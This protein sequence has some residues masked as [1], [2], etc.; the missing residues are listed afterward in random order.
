VGSWQTV[1][2]AGLDFPPLWVLFQAEQ[3]FRAV[4]AGSYGTS[5]QARPF[6]FFSAGKGRL[7]AL[8]LAA[9]NRPEAHYVQNMG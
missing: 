7:F 2:V 6:T 8:R 1:A 5:V 3:I 9:S 4:S